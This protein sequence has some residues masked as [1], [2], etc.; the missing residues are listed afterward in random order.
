MTV[1][2]PLGQ[3]T[4]YPR[5]YSP[6]LLFPIARAKARQALAIAQALPF[7]GEDRWTAYELSW[8]DARGKPEVR[9]AE[10]IIP[11]DSPAIIESKSFKLYLNSFNQTTFADEAEVSACI[12]RDLSQVAG[13]QVSVFFYAVDDQRAL[14]SVASQGYCLDQLPVA[15]DD[16]H[17]KPDE[18]AFDASRTVE[19]AMFYSHLL[20]TNCPVTGQPDWATVM[21]EYTGCAIV[22]EA[23]LRY[24][25]SFREHQDYHEHCVETI[26]CHLKHHCQPQNLSVYARYTRRGGLDINPFRSDYAQGQ[27]QLANRCLRTSRQ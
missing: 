21:I 5:H 6:E 10:L 19:Q 22:P 16:Y 4:R 7:S 23:L 20:K 25:V 14:A 27:S 9:L 11:C 2:N 13:A 12:Q 3:S 18:L 24:L 1:D 15:I 17:L 8:L 26:F